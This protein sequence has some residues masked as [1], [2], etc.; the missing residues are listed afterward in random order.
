MFM[1]VYR[2]RE[3]F[4]LVDVYFGSVFF[5]ERL[6]FGMTGCVDENKGRGWQ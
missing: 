5:G 3:M 4:I 2:L 1:D 6:E